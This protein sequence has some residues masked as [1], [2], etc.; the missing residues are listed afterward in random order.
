MSKL[1]VLP[2]YPKFPLT[3]WSFRKALEPIGKEAVMPPN[4]LATVLAMHPSDYFAFHRIIDM[5]VE[6]LTDAQ[7]KSADIIETSLMIA[8]EDSNNDV[9]DRA[10]FY[11][12]KVFSGG[13]SPTSYPERNQEADYLIQGEAELSFP[14]FLEDFLSGK[15]R[16]IYS[17]KDLDVLARN[18]FVKLS[19]GSKPLLENTPVPRWDLVDLSKY[20][21]AAIQYSRGC[22][23]D[24]DFCDIT[25][26][27]G[28]ESRTK[29]P[30][31][32]TSELDALI[33]EGYNGPVFI[34]DDNFIG[35][36]LNVKELLPAL[37]QW[38]DKNGWPF[39]FFTEASMNLAWPSN[40]EI[41]EGMV[42]S[43]FTEVFTG[44]ESIDE[45]VLTGMDKRQ[46]FRMSPLEAVHTIQKA[47]LTVS[48]G[49]IIGS[50]G[51]KPDV[52]EKLYQ[53]I[54]DAGIVIPMP[55]LLTAGKNTRLYNRLEKEGRLRFET[56]GNNTHQLGFNF[57]PQLDEKFL[58]DG[59]VSLLQKLFDDKNFY[60]RCR[61]LESN[62]GRHPDTSKANI[63]GMVAFGRSL[64]NQLFT[65]GGWEYFKYLAGSSLRN[66]KNFP[67]AVTNAIKLHHFK[68]VTKSMAQAHGY[69]T[70]TESYY[71]QFEQYL[72]E[73]SNDYT[74]S[75]KVSQVRKKARGILRKAEKG[76]KQL[77]EDFRSDA[78]QRYEVLKERLNQELEK[79][80]L[81]GQESISV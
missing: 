11:G 43:G 48:A 63:Q 61:T 24:C 36:K 15:A 62:L 17:E 21:S 66:P 8:Q 47:G 80:H 31:Q 38:Q 65:D 69:V 64:K 4:G 30:S 34:V 14:I 19:K 50:D 23:W 51:E 25:Q 79:Y 59:Y 72:K 35:N 26:L 45:D 58:V 12:K 54:Q 49:F 46:N 32:M 75:D 68:Y 81:P 42:D 33:R 44:I 16:R 1:K 3:F 5:N 7:I 57:E 78:I 27:Y 76:Y 22:V 2:V 28:R 70:K 9:V 13:P 55:G 73:L 40:K 6:P 60:D 52:F 74:L 39:Q 56:N 29:T 37:K 10:H 18:K 77:H 71:Y 41:L 20:G 53:F 67:E